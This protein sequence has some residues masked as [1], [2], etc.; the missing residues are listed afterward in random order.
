MPSIA[1]FE[2]DGVG[3]WYACIDAASPGQS[4]LTHPDK[5]QKLEIPMIFERFLTDSACASLLMG[6][7]QMDKR[8][9][10]EEAAEME[11]QRIVR[12]H[13]TPADGMR[14]K[15]GTR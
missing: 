9:A 11:L 12:R 1:Y 13:A 10:T 2:N 15:V 4:P 7:G 6:D 8:R 5:W 3:D 14:P